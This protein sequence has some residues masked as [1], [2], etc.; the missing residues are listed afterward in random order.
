MS[1]TRKVLTIIFSILIVAAFAF[2]LTWGIINWSKVKEGMAGNGLYTQ[3][4]VQNAY[5]DGY[6]TAL[7]DKEEYDNLINSYRDT[8]MSL[9]VRQQKI[10]NYANYFWNKQKNLCKLLFNK[11]IWTT[12]KKIEY[13]KKNLLRALRN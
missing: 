9:I 13:L 3:D 10:I 4:D 2:V 11:P 1:T 12:K 6:N 5:E 8:I 7:T